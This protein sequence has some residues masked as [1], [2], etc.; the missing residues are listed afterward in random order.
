[1]KARRMISVAGLCV[2]GCLIVGGSIWGCRA[3]KNY[4]ATDTKLLNEHRENAIKRVIDSRLG[5]QALRDSLA[6]DLLEKVVRTE[7]CKWSGNSTWNGEKKNPNWFS[8]TK[9]SD[10]MEVTCETSAIDEN[11]DEDKMVFKWK[12]SDS[13][14]VVGFEWGYSA[15]QDFV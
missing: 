12:V 15:L 14:G 2:A 13:R 8:S 10:G 1:M 6:S 3:W 4:E 5:S 11:G 9:S 7:P